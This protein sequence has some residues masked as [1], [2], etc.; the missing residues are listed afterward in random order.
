MSSGAGG[1]CTASLVA[2]RCCAGPGARSWTSPFVSAEL[3]AQ[4]QS[5]HQWRSCWKE[6]GA[7]AESQ[8]LLHPWAPLGDALRNLEVPP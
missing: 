2:S 4:S 5:G 6:H 1:A 3:S 7:S 8:V